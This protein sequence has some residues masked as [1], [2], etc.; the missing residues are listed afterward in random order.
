MPEQTREQQVEEALRRADGSAS[1][2]LHDLAAAVR[3]LRAALADAEHGRELARLDTEREQA[4]VSRLTAE[5][6]RL[7]EAVNA[8]ISRLA[9]ARAAMR[10][11]LKHDDTDQLDA[12]LLAESENGWIE[13]I[14]ALA[15][16]EEQAP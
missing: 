14:A 11:C 6:D 8:G 9:L 5:R 15:R 1:I 12:W 2:P 16:S 3:D 13:E 4:E 7:R 10:A